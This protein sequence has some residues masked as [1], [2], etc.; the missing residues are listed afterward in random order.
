[1]LHQQ[2]TQQG[3]TQIL[4][5]EKE[6]LA[7][8]WATERFHPY[9]YGIPFELVM[10]H[11]PLQAIYS[12]T[13]KPCAR[14]E[15]WVLR[16]QPYTFTVRYVPGKANIADPLSRLQQPSVQGPKPTELGEEAEEYVRFVAIS[17]TPRALTTREVERASAEDEELEEVRRCIETNK[18]DNCSVKTYAAISMELCTIGKLVLRGCRIVMPRKM[19]P[20][21]IALAHEGHLGIV[22]TKQNLRSRVWWPGMDKEAEKYCRSC[23]G[24]QI[25]AQASPPEP[26]RTT[27][28]PAGPW[29]DLSMDFLG[30]LPTGENVFV[31]VD[32]YSRYYEVELMK[33]ITAEKTIDALHRIFARHGLPISVSSDNGPQFKSAT[34]HEYLAHMGIMHHKV[35]P[36]WP[37][38]NGEVERQNE[39]LLKRMRIAH[40]E[41]GDWRRA[42]VDYMAAYRAT[43]QATTGKSPAELLFG[44]PMKTKMPEF[45]KDQVDLEVRDHDAERKGLSKLYA[46]QRRG[47]RE[48]DIQLGDK[49]IMIDEDKGKLDTNFKP[50]V[51]DVVAKA[52][53]RVT[54]EMPS[55][56][57][58]D[59][60][61]SHVRK[62]IE[63]EAQNEG[64]EERMVNPRVDIG[65]DD[66]VEVQHTGEMYRP[67]LSKPH[68]P[69][70]PQTVE[71]SAT[72]SAVRSRPRRS[73]C[74]NLPSKYKDY[75]MGGAEIEDI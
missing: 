74:G 71:K 61:S 63:P 55:G 50:V 60:N 65:L 22:A 16:M 42:I 68:T 52:G 26:I 29:Q 34:L 69:V 9:I 48:S 25:A 28:L 54:V 7:L 2:N 23:H 27:P 43:P 5:T 59:R 40:A 11:K 32:Y 57:R 66:P 15:R 31:V 8:V 46:D 37:Q 53:S 44:R 51:G 35:T 20:K 41:G 21:T 45:I 70:K 17:A 6:A 73:T 33:S 12:A 10:D 47:A 49:A 72:P 18:W 30:P 36:R 13:S 3:G 39:S 58:Y 4:P 56:A 62:Y 24:C 14:V 38:A 67:V 64:I 1:M 19:R 75:V